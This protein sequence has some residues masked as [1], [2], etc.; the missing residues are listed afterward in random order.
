M[1]LQCEGIIY[2][3]FGLKGIYWTR[4]CSATKFDEFYKS[5]IKREKNKSV[6]ALGLS[7]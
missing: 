1:V 2:H 7:K 5:C 4:G 3:Q 6:D